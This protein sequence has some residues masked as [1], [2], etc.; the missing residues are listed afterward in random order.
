MHS[1]QPYLPNKQ[2]QYILKSAC[3]HAMFRLGT[4]GR[5]LVANTAAMELVAPGWTTAAFGPI[6]M[7]SGY[8]AKSAAKC[9]P[10]SGLRTQPHAK[11]G[12]SKRR[13]VSA[14]LEHAYR[15]G[16]RGEVRPQALSTKSSTTAGTSATAAQTAAVKSPCQP[17]STPK[18]RLN[19]P[20]FIDVMVKNMVAIVEAKGNS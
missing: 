15:T 2:L 17:S 10:P 8:K 9:G 1:S 4:T 6:W 20:I 12:R 5:K 16:Q 7:K 19:K 14:S 11:C 18:S 13:R 3:G